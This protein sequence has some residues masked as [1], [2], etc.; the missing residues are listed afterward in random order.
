[1]NPGPLFFFA[2]EIYYQ[3]NCHPRSLYPL[4]LRQESQVHISSLSAF[5]FQMAI[6]RE[7]RA[8]WKSFCMQ[9]EFLDWRQSQCGCWR[10]Q[11]VECGGQLAQWSLLC[12]EKEKPSSSPQ[13]GSKPSACDSWPLEQLCQ[14]EFSLCT[15]PKWLIDNNPLVKGDHSRPR[16]TGKEGQ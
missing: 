2:W 3:W 9:K 8:L 4:S 7:P 13:Q 14:Q 1:M 10:S 5:A 12:R 11:G 15:R 6:F 16:N